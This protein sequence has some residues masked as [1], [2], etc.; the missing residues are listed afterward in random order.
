M[1][2]K[3]I[4]GLTSICLCVAPALAQP[5]QSITKSV[6]LDYPEPTT[7]AVA[8]TVNCAL[9]WYPHEAIVQGVVGKPLLSLMAGADGKPRDIV[10]EQSSGS[11]LLDQ[12]AISCVSHWTFDPA[13]WEGS[14]VAEPRWFAIIFA[15]NHEQ[16]ITNEAHPVLSKLCRVGKFY[17]SDAIKTCTEGTATASFL[18]EPDGS[19]K[20]VHLTSS[21]GN[22]SLDEATIKCVSATAYVPQDP[23]H[24]QHEIPW[25]MT[26]AWRLPS[27]CPIMNSAANK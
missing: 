26:V 8:H 12:A 3:L 25:Q 11:S 7:H 6:N 5:Q 4:A 23:D 16:P 17:P 9:N 19:L 14:P 27:M 18:I 21:T 10:L 22:A 2:R 24:I 20:K 1:H 15:L 13:T